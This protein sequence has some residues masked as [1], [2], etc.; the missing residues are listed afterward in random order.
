MFPDQPQS[1]PTPQS[2]PPVDYLNQIAPQAPKKKLF[3]PSPKFFA[4][5]GGLL[6][7]IVIIVSITV[8]AIA[9]ARREPLETLA[10]RL[11]STEQVVSDAQGQLKSSQLRTLNSNLKIYL[12]NTNRDIATPLMNNNVDIKKLSES[13][14]TKESPD[15]MM[16]RLEDARLNAIYD[17]TYAREMAYQLDRL[18]ALMQQIYETTSSQSLK[19]FLQSAYTNLLPTQEEF[20]DF[21][22]A[23]G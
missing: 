16:A 22:A 13:V 12:T 15:A 4:L 6:I 10:A 17:R 20:S 9:S 11:S 7:V 8:N 18:I 23:N 21:N 1:Q 3:T 2:P 5:I 19:S 14:T